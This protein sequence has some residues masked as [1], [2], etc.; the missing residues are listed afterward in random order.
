MEPFI[1]AYAKVKKT[2]WW[3]EEVSNNTLSLVKSVM[4]VRTDL[5]E[6]ANNTDFKRVSDNQ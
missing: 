3:H 6:A 2:L 5:S 4:A 1:D